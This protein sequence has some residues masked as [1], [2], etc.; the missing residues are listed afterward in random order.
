[1]QE[2]LEPYRDD[3][4]RGFEWF[5]WWRL[6][7]R[8]AGELRGHGQ[9]VVALAFSSDG[10]TL[11]S[12]GDEPS[13]ISWDPD[14]FEAR[15]V[16]PMTCQAQSLA[17]APDGSTIA[18]G[19]RDGVIR[20][21]NAGGREPSGQL[22]SGP[23]PVLA[24]HFRD[25][26][27]LTS[28]HLPNVTRTWDLPSGR[29]L[30]EWR[31]AD[32]PA[33]P[34]PDDHV[35]ACAISADGRSMAIAALDGTVFVRPTEPGDP[36]PSG[37]AGAT[38]D[39]TRDPIG[40]R[41]GAEDTFGGG[42]I[43]R[44]LAF[45]HDGRLLAIAGEDRL[46]A[47]RDRGRRSTLHTFRGHSAPVWSLAFSP[48]DR[49]LAA[50]S[51]DNTVSLWDVASGRLTMTLK[52]HG[53]P[54][55]AVAFSPDGQSVASGAADDMVL[56]WRVAGRDSDAPLAGH[57]DG[58]RTIAL[59]PDSSTVAT[60]GRDGRILFW[61]TATGE[62]LAAIG[63]DSPSNAEGL[64]GGVEATVYSN[65]GRWLI[66]AG[67]NAVL[68]LWD[69]RTHAFVSD[70]RGD[71]ENRTR[72][73]SLAVPREGP[74][75]AS[76][77][78]D[79]RVTLWDLARLVPLATYKAGAEEIFSLSF[80]PDGRTLASTSWTGKIH[81]QDLTGSR[82][83]RTLGLDGSRIFSLSFSPDGRT[84]ASGTYEGTLIFWDAPSWRPRGPQR[85]HTNT[86]TSLAFTPD[87][88]TL[89]SGARDDMIRLWDVATGELKST[90]KGH[91]GNVMG[92]AMSPEGRFLVSGS[93]DRTAR[94]W[95]AA[96]EDDIRRREG[97]ASVRSYGGD[98]SRL[99]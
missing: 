86:V 78:A 92:L 73:D 4:R 39:P 26:R 83:G 19:G 3:A 51:L 70:L 89:V 23:E 47:V 87:G 64:L 40:G 57:T 66:S 45:S 59:S 31:G 30:G 35:P 72:I 56:L 13:L 76:G 55:M 7:H 63:P 18:V 12:V 60:S 88:R 43:V 52:G 2:L 42:T 20:L 29:L 90:L 69:A 97:A 85:A 77:R 93:L 15:A 53:G 54:V 46:I 16:I 99:P 25:G 65:D 33:P 91:T 24:V 84:L 95:R 62:R 34:V 81:L 67:R 21:W 37:S 74:F 10:R 32:L 27:T 5:Y 36:A 6:A 41:L 58:V 98:V 14:R 28:V 50:A 82:D 80:S 68:R 49:L 79:G 11:V 71:R 8:P 61:S 94:I 1:M 48:D 22:R 17:L 44:S 75:V 38:A 9:R 96:S